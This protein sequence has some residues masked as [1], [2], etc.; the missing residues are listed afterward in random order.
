MSRIQ[1][2]FLSIALVSLFQFATAQNGSATYTLGQG[3]ATPAATSGTLTPGTPTQGT[4]IQGT[5]SDPS[6]ELSA[7]TS[8]ETLIMDYKSV[9]EAATLEE[10]VKAAAERFNL[11]KSQQEVWYTAAT[12]R[13]KAEKTAREQLQLNDPNN[14]KEGIYKGLRISQNTFYETI[15]GYLNPA[16]KQALETDRAILEEKRKRVAKLPPPPPPVPTVTIMPVDSA[17]IK[18]AEKAKNTGKKSKKKKKPAGA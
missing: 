10:E 9:Y 6:P 14:S 18:E 3:T 8:T 17:A 16:Q 5:L 1:F 13:R 7:N 15:V 11:T 12:D 4:P 2:K